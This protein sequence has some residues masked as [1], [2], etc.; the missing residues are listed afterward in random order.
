MVR[1]GF[2]LLSVLAAIA[3]L[4]ASPASGA[5]PPGAV[6]SIR[7]W[8]RCDGVT[9]DA[10]GVATA[11]AAAAAGGFVL[12][13][14][15]PV[16]VHVGDD[17]ARPIF[18]DNGLTVTFSAGGLFIVDNSLI[19]TFVIANSQDVT[20]KDWRVEYRGSVPIDM[21]T[22]HYHMDGKQIASAAIDPPGVAFNDSRLK[23][24]LTANRGL[25]FAKGQGPDWGG[26]SGETAIFYLVGQTSRVTVSGMK[27]FV[28]GAAGG[29]QFI[30]VAFMMVQG[31]RS[32][33]AIAATTPKDSAHFAVPSA[34]RFSNVDI[35]GSDMGWSGLAQDLVI[36]HVHSRRYGD[37]QDASGGEVGGHSLVGGKVVG[38]FAPPHLI[39]MGFV[40]TLDR[41]LHNRNIRITDVI[42]DGVRVG[43]ARDTP[44]KCCEGNSLSLKI[45]GDDSIVDGY[46]SGRPDGF[47]DVLDSHNLTIR[48]V[49]ATYDSSFMHDIYPGI[50]FPGAGYHGVTLENVTLT[51]VAKTTRQPPIWPSYDKDQGGTVFKNVRLILNDWSGP[52]GPAGIL[53]NPFLGDGD[54]IELVVAARAA[55][56]STSL[57]QNGRVVS[58]KAP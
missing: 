38:W 40:P 25:T 6:R 2:A 4:A 30:P 5:S 9:D 57:V 3:C 52:G 54:Q 15:C 22:G 27:L 19:P 51:D 39:Y 43:V 37:L 47:V 28:P 44:G 13:V 21:T 48:N 50:R 1:S 18:L 26:P 31:W 45:S 42:D 10:K 16:F 29:D 55:H 14:D 11:F 46:R 49:E 56:T 33:Q 41:A 24:W 20:L 12:N 8:T 17:V 35:D 23:T 34:L 7:D 36:E 58:V 32:N 53:R